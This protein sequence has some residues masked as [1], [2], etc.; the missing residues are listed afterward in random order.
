M[1]QLA[2]PG[3]YFIIQN[4]RKGP[5]SLQ[6]LIA[7]PEGYMVSKGQPALR[8]YAEMVAS[9]PLGILAHHIWGN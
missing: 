8:C 7:G 9:E 2:F 6:I 1:T 3:G 4:E 5:Q